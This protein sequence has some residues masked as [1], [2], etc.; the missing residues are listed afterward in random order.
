MKHLTILVPNIQTAN[1]TIACIVGAYQ[2]F[3]GANSYWEKKGNK[4]LFKIETAGVA[5]ESAFINGLLT[6]KPQINISAL[7]KTDLVLIPSLNPEFKQAM[8]DNMVLINWFREQYKNGAEVASMCTGAFMLA[9]SGLLDKRS[10]SIHW[11]S[12]DNFR[13]LFPEV[14]LKTEKLITD[15]NGIYTNGG[16]YSFLNLLLYLVE[17]YFDRETAIYCS[18]IFQVE[19]DRQ[20]QSAFTIFT[21][22]KSH[23]DEVII[24]AQQYIEDNF[25]EK[26]SVEDLSRK[27][28]IGRRNFDRRF[29]KATG[30]TPIEYLQRVKIESAKKAFET[31]RKTINEVMYEVGYSDVKAFREV[32]RKIT[33]LSPLDYKN[34]YNKDAD[35]MLSD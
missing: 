8:E 6:I 4:P 33:G 12:A 2:I 30:N 34:K 7:K 15:E 35:S 31:T 13:S 19:I 9:S 11:N 14:Q 16:G 29:I 26:I 28:A 10:C 22:Q 24:K 1:S 18:K 20:T 17:K 25:N 27:L 5:E 32:F 3:T 21:G 23:G